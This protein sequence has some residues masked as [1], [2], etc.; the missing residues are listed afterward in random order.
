MF[1]PFLFIILSSPLFADEILEAVDVKAEKEF[2]EFYFGSSE[3]MTE[4]DL[5]KSPHSLLGTSLERTSGVV[6]TQAGGPGGT[7]SY[8]IRGTESR[9]V[10]FTVDGLKLNDPSN[11][12]RFFDSAFFTLPFIRQIQIYKG[13]QSVLFGSDSLGGLVDMESRKGENAPQTRLNLS[14]GSFGT[15]SSTLGHDW[16]SKKH[17]GTLTW[18]DFHTDGISRLNKK[19]F[20]AKERDAA[21]ITQLTSSSEHKWKEKWQTDLLFS[22]IHGK[23]ELDDG[24]EDNSHDR[25]V[26]DQYLLQQKTHYEIDRSNAL[27]LRNGLNRHQRFL[28]TNSSGHE[29]FQGNLK[30]NEV[31]YRGEKKNISLLAGGASDLEDF[32][33]STVRKEITL[34]SIFAQA[35]VKKNDFSFLAGSRLDNHS[36]FGNFQTGSAGIKYKEL[37]LQYSKGFKAPSLYQLYAP[38]AYGL[39]IGND[40]L[41]PESNHALEAKWESKNDKYDHSIA[42]FRNDLSN[43]ITWTND[44]Y[45]N[46]KRF[47]AQGAEL[48]AKW[49][50][51]F[52][53]LAPNFTYQ[54]FLN[55]ESPVLRR[56]M[57]V[58]QMRVTSFLGELNE[59]F[60]L[61]KKSGSRKD[62]YNNQT[63]KLNG[64]ETVDAG[65]KFRKQRYDLGIQ[66]LNILNREYEEIFGYSVMPRSLFFNLGYRF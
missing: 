13:P 62:Q 6:A 11:T 17:N 61:F 30:Q 37:S 15:V 58:I 38:P 20:D 22:Y 53:E 54:E 12:D 63:V 45:R 23:N 51:E 29:S 50:N 3:K 14:A 28:N 39:Q 48:S 34:N 2:S 49:R 41:V 18:T 66:V 57:N 24:T 31:L 65:W 8:F 26:N 19:R 52:L 64:F 36:R 60:V 44:G 42:L 16:K 47:T 25:S 40:N 10:G 43:L 46:Q 21:D 9:H 32:T 5:E 55:D 33:T 59:I 35:V 7:T 4:F 27:S 1:W 56:P